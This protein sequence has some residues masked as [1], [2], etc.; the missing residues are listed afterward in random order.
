M[1]CK[2]RTK[3]DWILKTRLCRQLMVY[4][5]SSGVVQAAWSNGR[6][7]RLDY[8]DVISIINNTTNIT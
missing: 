3:Y 4:F 2:E 7:F 8:P 5:G 1:D 6:S